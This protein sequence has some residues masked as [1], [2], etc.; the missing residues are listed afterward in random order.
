MINLGWNEGTGRQMGQNVQEQPTRQ[1]VADIPR[2]GRRILAKGVEFATDTRQTGHNNNVLCLGGSGSGK[3]TGYVMPNIRNLDSNLVVAD[4]KNTLTIMFRKELEQKG[5]RV[6]QLNFADAENSEVGYNPLDFIERK[7]G[8]I[9]NEQQMVTVAG[10]LWNFTST[11]D[12]VWDIL[13]RD[14]LL[15][16]ISYCMEAE[17]REEQNLIRVAELH[18]EFN[19]PN[20]KYPILDWIADHPDSF[21]ARKYNAIKTNF[22]AEKMW[23]SVCGMANA[24]LSLFTFREAKNL[25]AAKQSIDLTRLGREKM[26]LFLNV[27]DLDPSMDTMVNLLYAQ[28]LQVLCRQADHEPDHRLQIPCHIICDDFGAQSKIENFA[29]I[30]SVI[31]SRDIYCSIMVQSISQLNAMYGAED[32]N[33][34]LTNCDHILYLGGQDLGTT[35][36]ISRRINKPAQSVM[37]KPA[38]KIWILANGSRPVL[39]DRILPGEA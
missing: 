10:A 35:E 27:S 18:A 36:F 5:Y 14:Y 29:R 38:E 37:Y 31:R 30:I 16:L 17:P 1:H 19:D 25:F 2:Y 6:C 11:K 7:E 39:A 26:V 24:A 15:F 9:L 13:N 3:T 23:S 20:Q 32:A 34:I 12:P 28:L 4:S 33:T 22:N 8:G 21:A